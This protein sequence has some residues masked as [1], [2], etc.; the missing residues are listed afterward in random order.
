VCKIAS[1]F[2][3][4]PTSDIKS[5]DCSTCTVHT[6]IECSLRPSDKSSFQKLF[7]S[8]HSAKIVSRKLELKIAFIS[9]KKQARLLAIVSNFGEG[10]L[11]VAFYG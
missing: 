6:M 1:G 7:E 5:A 2:A 11:T 3:P 9:K 10:G 4:F 8:C